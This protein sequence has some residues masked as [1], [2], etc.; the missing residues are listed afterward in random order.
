[1][2]SLTLGR[3]VKSDSHG[4]VVGDI[5]RRLVSR[6]MAQQIR[7]KVEK[8]TTPFQYA[9]STRA[10][11]EC[12]ARAIQAM[13]DA[14]PHCT[15]VSLNGIGAYVH[16]IAESNAEWVGAAHGVATMYCRSCCSSTDPR[17]PACGRIP[18][19]WST[20]CSRVKAESRVIALMLVLFSLGPA[21]MLL[22]PFK[23]VWSLVNVCWRFSM[24]STLL[25]SG[26]IAQKPCT[27]RSSR[28]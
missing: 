16:Y 1:M 18:K 14:N 3:G 9:L 26:Q 24:T 11:C 8:A 12:I 27:Q 6:T 23:T 17:L 22:W 13:T 5:I 19:G 28:N 4:I 10:G 2:A 7:K 15:V 21:L 25:M 20:K